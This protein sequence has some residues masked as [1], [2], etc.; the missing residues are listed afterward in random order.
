VRP[1][2]RATRPEATV[3]NEFPKL[4]LTLVSLWNKY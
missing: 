4:E 1:K 2:G 3:N